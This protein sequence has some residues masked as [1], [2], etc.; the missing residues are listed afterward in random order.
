MADQAPP[1]VVA[2]PVVEKDAAPDTRTCYN[3]GETG[4]IRPNCPNPAVEGA[5]PPKKKDRQRRERQRRCFNCGQPGHQAAECPSP[6]GNT[7][8]YEC[9]GEGHKSRECPM[10]AAAAPAPAKAE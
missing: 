3:C 10:K 2:A 4:H 6:A 5:A 8:C 1:P 9:G 7:A